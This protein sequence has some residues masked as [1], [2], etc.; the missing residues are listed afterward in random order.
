MKSF[1][2]NGEQKIEI[3]DPIISLFSLALLNF[4]DPKTKLSIKQHK[5]KFSTFNPNLPLQQIVSRTC[6]RDS[7]IELQNLPNP[8]YW[9]GIWF[10]ENKND[11]CFNSITNYK[12]KIELLFILAKNGVSQLINKAYD[13]KKLVSQYLN[14]TH[15]KI[16]ESTL[17]GSQIKPNELLIDDW[18]S[19]FIVKDMHQYWLNKEQ[20]MTLNI[21]LELLENI[22]Y[23]SEQKISLKDSIQENIN[24]LLNQLESVNYLKNFLII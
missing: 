20:L 18:N 15:L 10:F 11:E 4:M 19:N 7:F 16:L 24:I 6:F 21:M 22:K 13:D 3:I 17:S 23:K 14:N 1:F 2:E 8:L 9:G 5:I 12:N